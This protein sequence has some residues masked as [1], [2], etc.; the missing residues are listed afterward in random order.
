M[1]QNPRN[2]KHLAVNCVGVRSFATFAMFAGRIAPPTV[3]LN[4]KSK[5]TASVQFRVPI[6]SKHGQHP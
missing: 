1:L 4:M 5:A 3:R 6:F 2:S